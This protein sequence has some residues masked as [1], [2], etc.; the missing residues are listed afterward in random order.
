MTPSVSC[1]CLDAPYTY[2]RSSKLP[3]SLAVSHCLVHSPLTTNH[4]SLLTTPPTHPPTHSLA[5]L[6]AAALLPD[7]LSSLLDVGLR[8]L[9]SLLDVG[10]RDLTDLIHTST[11]TSTSTSTGAEVMGDKFK[12]LLDTVAGPLRV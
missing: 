2:T 7:V 10:L 4:Y 6:A 5:L 12:H 8:D 3:P 11:S 1:S 9:S